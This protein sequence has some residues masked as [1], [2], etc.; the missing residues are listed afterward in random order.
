MTRLFHVSDLHFGREDEAAVLWFA[1]AVRA[2]R[3]DAV[4][5]TG[6]LTMRATSAEYASAARY[7]QGLG[8]PVTVEPGNHDIPLYNVAARLLTPCAKYGRMERAIE[9]P[10]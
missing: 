1:D 5:M 9:T 8:V 6:D 2:E 3:P 10:V 7:L 4:V